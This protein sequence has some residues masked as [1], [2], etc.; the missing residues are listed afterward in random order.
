MS[1][2]SV[3]NSNDS[4]YISISIT[5]DKEIKRLNKKYLGKDKPTDVLSFNIDRKLE[6]G[7]YYLG[8]VVVNKEQAK[9]Q[10]KDFKNSLEEEISELAAHGI[11][12]L[13]GLHHEHDE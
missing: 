9:R 6:D 4:L 8:D 11:C 5:N 2:S 7:T 3:L 13:L 10:M 12:H 1:K